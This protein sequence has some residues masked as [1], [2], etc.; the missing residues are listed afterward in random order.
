MY[1]AQQ[2][3]HMEAVSGL[4]VGTSFSLYIYV[5]RLCNGNFVFFYSGVV[6]NKG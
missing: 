4:S 5:D 2:L 3:A 1:V 6:E